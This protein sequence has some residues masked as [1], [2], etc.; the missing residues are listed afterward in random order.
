MRLTG[1]LV[2]ASLAGLFD[3][4]VGSRALLSDT[5]LPACLVP[6]LPPPLAPPATATGLTLPRLAPLLTG[7]AEQPSPACTWSWS[8]RRLGEAATARCWLGSGCMRWRWRQRHVTMP[9]TG[10]PPG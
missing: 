6:S 10:S 8:T 4:V 3:A 7:L 5:R 9:C 2:G 1:L